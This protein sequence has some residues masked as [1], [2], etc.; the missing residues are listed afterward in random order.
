MEGLA[1][2]DVSVFYGHLA[3]FT[4]IW[5]ILWLF[6]I[7]VGYL[8]Y[9][10]PVLVCCTKK[11]LATAVVSLRKPIGLTVFESLRRKLINFL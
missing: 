3:Y 1:T 8:V 7:F 5:Y 9:I 6:G 2:G 10:F 4:A 11:N